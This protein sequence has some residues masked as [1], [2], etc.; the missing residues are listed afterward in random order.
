MKKASLLAARNEKSLQG[1]TLQPKAEL[2]GKGQPWQPQVCVTLRRNL[3]HHLDDRGQWAPSAGLG[4]VQ[5][6]EQHKQP[7]N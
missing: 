7:G 1:R 4:G 2:F 6:Q 5:A 3:L